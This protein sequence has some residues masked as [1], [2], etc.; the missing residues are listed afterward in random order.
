MR[1]ALFVTCL[2]DTLFPDAGIATVRVLERLGHDVEFPEAQTCCGQLHFNTGYQ[3]AAAALARRF[4]QV[5]A[6]ADVVVAPSASCVAMVREF[7]PYLAEQIDDADLARDVRELIPRVVELTE[8]LV[9]RLGVTEVGASFRH[10]VTYHPTCHSL[11]ALRLGDAPFALLRAVDGLDLVELPRANECCGFGGTFAMKNAETSTRD[12]RRQARGSH[13]DEC[14][15]GCRG[16]HVVPDADRR[17]AVSSWGRRANPARRRDPGGDMSKAFSA[18][19]H[20]ALRNAQLRRNLHVATTTIRGKRAAV[21][22]ERADWEELRSAGEALKQ[23]VLRHLDHYLLRFESA[24]TQAGGVVHWARDAQDA[25]EIVVGLVRRTGAREVVKVKSLTTDEIGVN[26]ALA[27]A[28][29]RAIETDLAELIC[30]LAG[31]K[32]SHILVPAIHKNRV[33]IRDLFRRE[34]GQPE[35]SDGQASSPRQHVR[36]YARDSS[37]RPLRSA[38]R[39]SQWPRL[40]RSASSSPKGTDVSARRC[41]GR[42]SR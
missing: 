24:V 16:R 31:D 10:R 34:L 18:G 22:A 42:S 33:E 3:D 4:V 23:R 6:E 26:D 25:N 32:P 29:V 36:T 40:E 38:A 13:G 39:T 27:T 5:F 21:T 12:S 28:G 15:G 8:F 11:R 35:I 19:A 1:V 20:E 7:Y 17:G 2:N 37:R 41:R 14:R 9:T 30:Q